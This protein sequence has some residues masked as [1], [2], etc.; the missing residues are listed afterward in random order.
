MTNAPTHYTLSCNN[1]ITYYTCV[2]YC[3]YLVFL[4]LIF[5]GISS[6]GDSYQKALFA[7][8]EKQLV[9]SLEVSGWGVRLVCQANN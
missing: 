3:S 7:T 4:P 8:L 5:L 9:A 1:S 2:Y 6:F